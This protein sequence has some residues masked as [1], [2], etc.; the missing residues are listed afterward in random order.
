MRLSKHHLIFLLELRGLLGV[1]FVWNCLCSSIWAEKQISAEWVET[2]LNADQ[3]KRNFR[4][5]VV[6]EDS[7]RSIVADSA[8]VR[9]ED[10][11]YL[12]IH[13]VNYRDTSR[14]VR[15]DSL[16]FQD[17]GGVATFFGNVFLKN[18]N[19]KI[20]AQTVR[21]STEKNVLDASGGI[22]LILSDERTLKAFSLRYDLNAEQGV[23]AGQA[24]LQVL[25]R[26]GDT[27]KARS[28][29]VV[30]AQEGKDLFL[31]GNVDIQ[32]ATTRAR[33]QFAT[34]S[35]SAVV[36]SGQPSVAWTDLAS[37]DSVSAYAKR[38]TLAMV[39]Q[40]LHSISLT[41]SVVIHSVTVKD[42]LNSIQNIDADSAQ[43]VFFN[44][45]PSTVSAQGAVQFDLFSAEIALAALSGRRLELVYQNS[46]IDSLIMDGP[47]TGRY[48]AKDR[49]AESRL[50]G[51]QCLIWFNG[52]DLEKMAI[53]DEARCT[54]AD[55]NEVTVSGDYLLLDFVAGRLARIEADG[56][57]QGYYNSKKEASP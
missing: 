54:H 33:A 29:S 30:F 41:D 2:L 32:Q 1:L 26:S 22:D 7:A 24:H 20:T 10:G 44:Q 43:I 40:S 37:G 52:G 21:F 38:I 8:H 35:D 53:V 16:K 3:T 15:A 4:G 49:A 11:F 12:F 31:G 42:T 51:K 46:Q 19:R 5:A 9:V 45:K 36:L 13:Q 28:D 55:S 17:N 48:V 27:L 14:E 50:G 47:F 6:Y 56:G 57:V 23:L 18:G 25:G 39:D 34:Y